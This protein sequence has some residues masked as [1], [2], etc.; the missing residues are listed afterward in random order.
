MARA[1]AV[2]SEAMN[3]RCLIWMFL[4]RRDFGSNPGISTRASGQPGNYNRLI[5]NLPPTMNM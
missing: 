3:A 5:K 2:P 4:P 1:R